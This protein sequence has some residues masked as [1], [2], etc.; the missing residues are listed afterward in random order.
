MI[1]RL[2]TSSRDINVE[3]DITGQ[4]KVQSLLLPHTSCAVLGKLI[5]LSSDTHL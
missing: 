3:E 2:T 1:S 4:K 5:S